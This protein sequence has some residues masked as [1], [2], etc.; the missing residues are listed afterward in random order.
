[1]KYYSAC[2]KCRDILKYLLTIFERATAI[3][4]TAK[5]QKQP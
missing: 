3:E 4:C 1:M 2:S 5:Q